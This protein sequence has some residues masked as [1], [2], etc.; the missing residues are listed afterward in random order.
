MEIEKSMKNQGKKARKEAH[1]LI[2]LHD[3]LCKT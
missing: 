2:Q 3:I 1:N